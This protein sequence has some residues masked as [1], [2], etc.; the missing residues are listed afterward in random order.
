MCLRLQLTRLM[1][2][3]VWLWL[4]LVGIFL[5]LPVLVWQ[6]WI[7]TDFVLL[8]IGIVLIPATLWLGVRHGWSALVFWT[9]DPVLEKVY[10]RL[11]VWRFIF[12]A[13]CI[14]GYA[15]IFFPDRML[16]LPSRNFSV[17][18]LLAIVY[19]LLS[20]YPQELLYRGFFFIRYRRLFPTVWLI[21]LM[22]SIC[23]AWMHIVFESVIS[24]TFTLAGGMLFAHTYSRTR[25]LRLV[26]FEHTLYGELIFIS[27]YAQDFLQASL[28]HKIM[29]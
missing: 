22:S 16:D 2:S 13:S 26:C 12:L 17:W 10:L 8:P 25:S 24:I 23:F 9:G 28:F 11:V 4:E 21:L 15:M 1:Q 20:V 29:Q 19:P 5:A 27:G 6:G 3:K 14:I 18:L 7:S